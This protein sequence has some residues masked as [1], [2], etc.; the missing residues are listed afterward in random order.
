MLTFQRHHL[1]L[2]RKLPFLCFLSVLLKLPFNCLKFSL[3]EKFKNIR[4]LPFIVIVL[5]FLFL[6]GVESSEKKRIIFI[7]GGIILISNT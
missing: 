1:T 7:R 3:V 6:H 4:L 5:K 2:M